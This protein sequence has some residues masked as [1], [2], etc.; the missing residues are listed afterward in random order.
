MT[1]S[2]TTEILRFLTK[3]LGIYAEL[4]VTMAT[5]PMIPPENWIKIGF[6]AL[7]NKP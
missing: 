4:S 2:G 7:I 5:F 1:T 3:S 6:F